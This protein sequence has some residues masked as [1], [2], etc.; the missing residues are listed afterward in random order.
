M[1]AELYAL[2]VAEGA[3]S[4]MVRSSAAAAAAGL[5]LSSGILVHYEIIIM[6]TCFVSFLCEITYDFI[7]I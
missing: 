1:T 2:S 4:V 5:G 7:Y 6:I 3:V